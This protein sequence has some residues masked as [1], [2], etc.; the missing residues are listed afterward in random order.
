ME[1]WES[2]W[3]VP[4]SIEIHILRCKTEGSASFLQ[5][6][7]TTDMEYQVTAKMMARVELWPI[8][9]TSE[10]VGISVFEI[11]PNCWISLFTY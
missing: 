4:G 8:K 1:S 9:S 6:P 2:A 3:H 7:T 5:I 11:N 10:Q